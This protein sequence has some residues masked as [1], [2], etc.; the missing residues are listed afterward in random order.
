[1]QTVYWKIAYLNFFKKVVYE[2]LG[3]WHTAITLD[4]MQ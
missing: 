2:I 1:M 3:K 4:V